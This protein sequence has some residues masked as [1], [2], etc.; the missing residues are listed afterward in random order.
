M[1][2]TVLT[3]FLAF[4]FNQGFSQLD[5]A[6]VRQRIRQCADSL[7][8]GFLRS[9]W[10]LF[11]RYTYPPLIG[12]IGGKD[13]FVSKMKESFDEIPDSS[14]KRYEPGKVLQVIKTPMDIQA[15]VELHSLIEWRGLRITSTHH[16]IAESW[17]GGQHWT[18]FDSQ[19]DI[20]KT[21]QIKRDLSPLLQIPPKQEKV[22]AL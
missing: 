10:D 7:A 20:E 9:D 16:L 13:A 6:F 2:K 4:L 1:K 5:T 21:Q 8:T 14:W 12:A 22:E 3:F 18:F 11:A 19:N 15:V 17:N